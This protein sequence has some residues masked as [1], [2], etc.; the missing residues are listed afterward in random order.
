MYARVHTIPNSNRAIYGEIFKVVVGLE[1][2]ICTEHARDG[3]AT[4]L[5]W[6]IRVFASVNNAKP[7][8][9]REGMIDAQL[10]LALA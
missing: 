3:R 2:E 6:L 5:T 10:S 8:A 4:G 9:K 1:A 7:I